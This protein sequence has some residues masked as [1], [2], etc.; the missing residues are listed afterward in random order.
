MLE[1]NGKQFNSF[2]DVAT[3]LSARDYK[4]LPGFR[5]TA[6]YERKDDEQS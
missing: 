1:K 4:G 2:T 6:I 3:T 5:G